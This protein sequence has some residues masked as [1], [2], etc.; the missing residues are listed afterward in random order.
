MTD[1]KHDPT[2]GPG[3]API[4]RTDEPTFVATPE[5]PLVEEDGNQS[6]VRAVDAPPLPTGND[7]TIAP[8]T[9]RVPPSSPDSTVRS[10]KA[11]SSLLDAD[12]DLSSATLPPKHSE[13]APTPAE[14]TQRITADKGRIPRQVDTQSD[15]LVP[16]QVASPPPESRTE[17]LSAESRPVRRVNT[18]ADTI[19]PSDLPPS[20]T[21]AQLAEELVPE[22]P[23]DQTAFRTDVHGRARPQE[24][25]QNQTEAAGRGR[26]T[27]ATPDV[28]DSHSETYFPAPS[29][30]GLVSRLSNDG[31]A[32]GVSQQAPPAPGPDQQIRG[33]EIL[34]TLGRGG[35]GVVFKARQVGLNRI[36]ALKMILAAAHASEEDIGRFKVEAEA[37]ARLQHPNIVQIYEVGELN[38]K[39]Y[40]SLEFVSGGSLDKKLTGTPLAPRYSAD[41]VEKIARGIDAAHR[42]GIVHRDLKPANIMLTAD[43]EPKITDFGLAKKMDPSEV[44][45][46]QDGSIMGTPSYMSPEQAAGKVRDVG[47]AA[48]TY[49]LGA[50]L[51]DLL[52]G[53]PPFKGETIMDTLY[54]VMSTEPV[55]PCRLQPKL[56]KD[57]ETICLKCL[58]K[59]IPKRYASAGDMADDLRRWLHGEP[60][61]ARPVGMVEKAAKWAKRRPTAA[62]LVLVSVLAVLSLIVG[63]FTFAHMESARADQEREFAENEARL[64]GTA[65]QNEAEAKEQKALAEVRFKH[66]L[67][68]LRRADA[69]FVRSNKAIDAI[70]L[71]KKLS[72]PRLE[73]VRRDILLTSK[74]FYQDVLRE[75]SQQA[76]ERVVP[77]ERRRN[78]EMYRELADIQEKLGEYEPAEKSYRAALE[79]FNQ[80]NED[81][82]D[83]PEARSRQGTVYNNLAVLLHKTKRNQDADAALAKS[84]GIKEDL[85]KEYPEARRYRFDLANGYLNRGDLR[86]A[87]QRQA[88]E[89]AD[90]FSK[91]AGIFATLAKQFPNEVVYQSSAAKANTSMAVCF[92]LLKQFADAEAAY[93]QAIAFWQPLISLYP[94]DADYRG[95]LARAKL[96]LGGLWHVSG[97]LEPARQSYREAAAVFQS[98]NEEFPQN[99]DYREALADTYINLGAASQA[100]KRADA[101]T[102]AFRQALPLLKRLAVDLPAEPA[103]RVKLADAY[104][105]LAI[106]LVATARHDEAD[107]AWHEAIAV[108]ENLI[109]DF[110]NQPAHWQKLMAYYKNVLN[111]WVTLQRAKEIEKVARELAAAQ[112]Q[113]VQAFP[114]SAE[115]KNDLGTTLSSLAEM[116]IGSDRI[117]DAKPLLEK[118]I[119]KQRDAVK[120]KSNDAEYVKSL[121]ASY[122]LLIDVL[123]RM[124]EPADAVKSAQELL[125]AAPANSPHFF[126]IACVLARG[127]AAVQKDEKLSE[128]QRRELAKTC[129]DEAM[130]HLRR[131]VA[132]GYKEVDQLKNDEV[133]SPLR[134]RPDFQELVA[135]LQEK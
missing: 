26:D 32:K 73:P 44:S 1:Q 92:T 81:F 77:T 54:D 60:I 103:Y 126:R 33:Y 120:M 59:E 84:L 117:K 69:A 5:K 129:G 90:D 13:P 11:S 6:T 37:V 17:R 45:Q 93:Q 58:E 2:I 96:N 125:K 135:K 101:A 71:N 115:F 36:V 94:K 64:R 63:G 122:S 127:M 109:A 104:N 42:A 10:L 108:A 23:A 75:R 18:D 12:V 98:L 43:G 25:L 46:T 123:V 70:V 82:P 106:A 40:F 22:P 80:L 39:P 124:G 48:D 27:M 134:N 16:G 100:A 116:L 66:A 61:R 30:P 87:G 130:I 47:P 65:E 72:D 78:G 74:S 38:Q 85:T 91:A 121:C 50:I 8:T 119:V 35:M 15:T 21:R 51:Y 99:P 4:V 68:S 24:V 34:G 53:R 114:Q 128:A 112:E 113:R 19:A 83:D 14:G 111:L 86:L 49:A 131:A 29:T 133:F 110:A 41:L 52:T 67:D 9:K 105:D 55:P 97:R 89:A 95:E 62:A 76:I 20:R 102:E 132:Q 57:L 107:E 28:F 118:A 56:P 88:R 3:G 31:T 7:E 79:Y